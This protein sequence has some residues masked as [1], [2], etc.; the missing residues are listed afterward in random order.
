ML[1]DAE[2]TAD[3][4]TV[5]ATVTATDPATGDSVTLTT[6]GPGAAAI[7]RDIPR[8]WP[9]ALDRIVEELGA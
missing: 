7:V 8:W 1:I 3:A 2:A 5:T 6:R 4:I 9:D